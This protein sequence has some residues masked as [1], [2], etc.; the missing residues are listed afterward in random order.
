MKIIGFCIL[1]LISFD[2]KAQDFISQ[3]RLF[4]KLKL[5]KELQSD[6]DQSRTGSI[7]VTRLQGSHFKTQDEKIDSLQSILHD[8]QKK[9][10]INL[11]KNDSIFILVFNDQ[12]TDNER[13]YFWNSTN[14]LYYEF[15]QKMLINNKSQPI[16]TKKYD[17]ELQ[18]ST[19]AGYSIVTKDDTLRNL[20]KQGKYRE[21]RQLAE[22]HRMDG[23]ETC[24]IIFCRKES[25]VYKFR[26]IKLPSFEFIMTK[27]K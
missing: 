11:T 8:F 24:L 22:S 5:A 6:T 25:D 9:K 13:T 3:Y 2:S 7:K 17:L 15:Q 23:G 16:I 26:Q 19:D 10:G 12:R 21:I 18:H 27:R 1:C 14:S 20:L 4:W